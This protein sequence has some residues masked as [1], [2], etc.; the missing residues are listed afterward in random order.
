MNLLKILKT[1]YATKH[2]DKNKVIPEQE[3]EQIKALLQLSPSSVN[4]QPWHFIIAKTD[5]AKRK[6]AGSTEGG[7]E[8]NKEKILSASHVVVMCARN[9]LSEEYLSHLLELEDKAGR[10]PA[11][12]F[13]EQNNLARSFFVNLHEKQL[14]DL[15]HWIEKQVYLNMGSLLL[16][17]ATLGIDA[18]PM[19]GFDLSKI[20][21]TFSLNDKGLHAV[22]I[23]AL[24]YREEDDFNYNLPKSRL[25]Q[26]EII[27]DI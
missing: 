13:K 1:R 19:E 3:L 2:F 8:F 11:A 15:S 20:D 5:D 6:I 23:V 10:Y 9:T 26:S 17:A 16:G 12:E 4:T 14:G 7:Y 24:G 21:S 18:L 25:P 22:T 27:T